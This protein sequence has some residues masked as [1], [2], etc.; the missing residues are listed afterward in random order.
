MNIA[1]AYVTL[2]RNN[3]CGI[4]FVR[5]FPYILFL[6]SLTGKPLTWI[7]FNTKIIRLAIAYLTTPNQRRFINQS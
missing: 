6:I 7:K 3:R 5:T 4:S 2:R 1:R